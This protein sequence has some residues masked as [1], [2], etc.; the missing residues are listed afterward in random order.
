MGDWV[1]YHSDHWTC[2]KQEEVKKNDKY[3]NEEKTRTNAKTQLERYIFFYERYVNHDKSEKAAA[4][5]MN[6]IH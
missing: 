2:N 5:H 4:K 1:K 3:I 6:V